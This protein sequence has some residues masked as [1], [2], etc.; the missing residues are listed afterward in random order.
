MPEI[1]ADAAVQFD[2][3]DTA[4]IAEVCLRLIDSADLRAGLAAKGLERSKRFSWDKAGRQC[5]DALVQ[6]SVAIRQR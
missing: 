1:V 4:S 2:P 3:F 6:V 5:A